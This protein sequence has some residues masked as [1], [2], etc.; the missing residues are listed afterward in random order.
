MGI[1][2]GLLFLLL[3]LATSVAVMYLILKVMSNE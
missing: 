2:H 3:G 1:E